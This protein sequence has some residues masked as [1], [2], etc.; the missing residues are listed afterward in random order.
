MTRVTFGLFLFGLFPSVSAASDRLRA[1]DENVSLLLSVFIMTYLEC[2]GQFS[3]IS[4]FAV[5]PCIVFVLMIAQTAQRDSSYHYTYCG[6][7]K[8]LSVLS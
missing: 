1:D 3:V 4:H 8:Q 5:D 6:M 2:Y 7:T